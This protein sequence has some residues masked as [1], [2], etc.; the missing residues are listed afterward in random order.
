RRPD[1]QGLLEH[2]VRI[3][4]DTAARGRA[5]PMVRDHGALLGKALDVLGLTRHVG[6]R[7]EEREIRVLM[8][9][10]L[11]HAVERLLHVLPQGIAV[12]PDDHAA[13]DARV[14]GELRLCNDVVVP[15]REIL[16]LLRQLLCHETI[17]PKKETTLTNAKP[18][19][20]PGKGG[21]N[22]S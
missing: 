16:A 19:L 7:D 22:H 10:F 4:L 13:L 9:G 11:E 15:G 3:G 20:Y 14:L 12:R 18:L 5:Q 6:L 2:T 8:P 1:D 17:T 21:I